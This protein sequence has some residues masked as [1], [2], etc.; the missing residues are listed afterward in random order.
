MRY[1]L[2]RLSQDRREET[3][4]I[5]VTESLRLIP[6]DRYLTKRYT[7]IV[8]PQPQDKR[9]GDEVVMDIIERAGLQL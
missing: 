3:Y 9:T 6:Q 4:R 1:V 5:F 7:E 8:N 2:A